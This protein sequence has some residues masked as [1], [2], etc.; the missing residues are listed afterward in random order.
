MHRALS[1]GFL[2]A[3]PQYQAN[4]KSPV[5][6]LLHCCVNLYDPGPTIQYRLAPKRKQHN[7]IFI[8]R[9]PV[10]AV[11]DDPILDHFLTIHP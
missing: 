6:Q 5:R 9:H 3:D 1:V 2:H 10:I 4:D 11:C 8:I 7:S